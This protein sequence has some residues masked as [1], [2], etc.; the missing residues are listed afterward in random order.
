[1]LEKFQILQIDPDFKTEALGVF[2]PTGTSRA[3][4][5]S[6]TQLIGGSEGVLDLGCG[7][8]ILGLE[9]KSRYPNITLSM[10]DISPESTSLAELND[11]RCNPDTRSNIRTGSL[12]E[13]W[14]GEK[15]DF[16]LSDVSGVI[17]EI[18]KY[19]GW[20]NDVPNE[21]GIHGTDLAVQVIHAAKD[22]LAK[23]DSIFLMPIISLA[24]ENLQLEALKGEFPYVTKINT[25]QF[26]ITSEGTDAH[27]F[28]ESF[29]DVK[30][31]TLAG[32]VLFTTTVY[33]GSQIGLT[34]RNK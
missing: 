27:L 24:N 26:P 19:F 2:T 32:M 12:F 17:P 18:G 30:L 13:P 20:F 25:F 34:G 11:S 3:M 22:F 7:S 6:A 5:T 16:I 33:A 15:F 4:L 14:K 29:K 10:S 8:G 9:L 28:L 1:M 21:S 23:L 31:T